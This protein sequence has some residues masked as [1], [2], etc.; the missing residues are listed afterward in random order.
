MATYAQNAAVR[1][2]AARNA[3]QDRFLDAQHARFDATAGEVRA[4]WERYSFAVV[5]EGSKT[6]QDAYRA[7]WERI[8]G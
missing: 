4:K 7:G 2:R 6:S 5:G 1:E 8:F 3:A